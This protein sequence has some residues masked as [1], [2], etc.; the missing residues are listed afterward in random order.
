MSRTAFTHRSVLLAAT[1]AEFTEELTALAG[2]RR[3]PA[4]ISGT[5]T[6]RDRAVFVFPGHGSQWAG[7]TADLLDTS[8]VFLASIRATAEA[9]APYVDWSLEDVLR[10]VP[11]AP[12]LD[13]IDVIQPA[14]FATALGLAALWRSFGIEP[15]AVV[16]H[17][18]GELAAAVVAG[19]LSLEDGA[20]A[21]ALWGKAQARLAGRGSMLSVLLP[22]EEVRTRLAAWD[23][24]LTV[25]GINGPRS[26]AVAGDLDAVERLQEELTAE[27]VRARRVAIDYAPHCAHM[28]EIHEELLTVLAPLR[29]RKGSIPFYSGL[30]GAQLD[31]RSL[32][33]SYWFRSLREAVLFE[34]GIRCLAD[35]ELFVEISPHPVMTLPVEQTL[36][37]TD[38]TAVVVGSLR[39]GADGPHRFLSSVAE[40]YAHGAPVDWSPVF[41][42]DAAIVDLPTYPFRHDT[43][44][45]APAPFGS[46]GDPERTTGFLMDLVR[47]EVALVLG[48]GKGADIDPTRSFTDLGLDSAT[49]VELRNRLVAAT[50]LKLP[51]TLLFDRPTP[52]KLVARLAELS[53]VVA[54]HE[55]VSR[56]LARRTAS[57]DEPIAIVSMACRFPG[58]V[59]SPED[60]WRLLVEERD[61]VSEFPGNRGW[62]LETLFDG[63]PDRAGT[64]YTR[65]GGFLHDVDRFDAEFFGISPREATAMDPQQRM[66]LETVWE[67]VER[68]GI[69]PAALRGSGTGVYVGA[70]AQ[71]YGPRLHEAGEG[72]G[73]Y[74]LTGTYTSVVSGRASYTLGLEGPAVTVDTA[75]SASSWPCTRP[76]RHCGPAS[77]SWPSPAV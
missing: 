45:A 36:E 41:P 14:L 1:E 73:G 23:G 57:S 40:A 32:D 20:R 34:S 24:K 39:R 62:A 70:M 11:G 25:A 16:G 12:G 27:G 50:G 22:L 53:G 66:V 29:P 58:G 18:I 21:G 52:E 10:E 55:P 4:R 7:M 28:D 59:A 37:T 2:G 71:D 48:R 44:E 13:R 74:L 19:G 61:A 46:G 33:A 38:S 5:A 77:A 60:L 69:D 47:S 9:L 56:A 68:A 8:D 42:A 17:S 76:R 35:H 3:G 26:I 43:P 67:A 75:C 72:V 64:S 51:T 15:A 54:A 6:R 63:D 65:Q 31:T 49:A 30:T